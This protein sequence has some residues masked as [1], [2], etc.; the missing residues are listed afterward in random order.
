MVN[1]EKIVTGLTHFKQWLEDAGEVRY[2]GLD[3]PVRS[4]YV[5]KMKRED[6]GKFPRT[7]SNHAGGER[8]RGRSTPK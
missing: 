3:L 4:K 5:A 7:K 2:S 8:S 1:P 6:N